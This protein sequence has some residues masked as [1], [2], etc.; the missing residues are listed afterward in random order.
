MVRFARVVAVGAP[1]HITQRGNARRFILE[2]DTERSVYL[3]LLQQGVQRHG[4]ISSFGQRRRGVSLLPER[5]R[6]PEHCIYWRSTPSSRS[7]MDRIVDSCRSLLGE[8]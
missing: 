5:R 6:H 1:H 7:S 3:A 8:G 4:V 2:D